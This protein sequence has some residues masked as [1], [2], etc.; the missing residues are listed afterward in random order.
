MKQVETTSEE[1]VRLMQVVAEDKDMLQWL[2]SLEKLPGN[3]RYSHIRSMAERMQADRVNPDLVAALRSL[4]SAEVYK[5]A[6]KTVRD[7]SR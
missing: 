3:L 6:V 5:A 2:L 1:F 4:T 7:F